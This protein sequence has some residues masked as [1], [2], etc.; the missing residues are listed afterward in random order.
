VKT[1][2][3]R[4][5]CPKFEDTKVGK[6]NGDHSVF[7]ENLEECIN[8]FQQYIVGDDGY[9]DGGLVL[10]TRAQDEE[11]NWHSSMCVRPIS[12]L[13]NGD[14]IQL[15][16]KNGDVFK[17]VVDR[18]LRVGLD[19]EVKKAADKAERLAQIEEE[20]AAL[21]WEKAMLL[22]E[23]PEEPRE[24]SSATSSLLMAAGVI[25]GAL[26]TKSDTPAARVQCDDAVSE[27]VEESVQTV[28][29]GR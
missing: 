21:I 27:A 18:S 22:D 19:P 8:H 24:Q 23:K 12:A 29:L 13:E 3:T 17:L 1:Y 16:G 11:G 10:A 26:L 25:G 7:I 2:P 4:V 20:M 9:F 6:E 28:L 5:L 15:N 14:S